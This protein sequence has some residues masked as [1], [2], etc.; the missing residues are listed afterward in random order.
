ML[1]WC[2]EESAALLATIPALGFVFRWVKKCWQ[3]VWKRFLTRDTQQVLKLLEERTLLQ[4][5]VIRL[6]TEAAETKEKFRLLH[7][8]CWEYHCSLIIEPSEPT[9]C[10]DCIADEDKYHAWEE[11][12]NGE[13]TASLSCSCPACA[14]FDPAPVTPRSLPNLPVTRPQ[15]PEEIVT[16]WARNL[17]LIK[18][19]EISPNVRNEIT[20]LLYSTSFKK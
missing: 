3:E 7:E 4:Q 19:L 15:S 1:H 9:R 6:E 16:D 11:Y 17:A 12:R 10:M 13:H 14:D 8:T 5:K 18:G 2:P 20:Q